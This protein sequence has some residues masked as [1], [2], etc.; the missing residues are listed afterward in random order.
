MIL[1]INVTSIY[2]QVNS[3]N[4]LSKFDKAWL[5]K[6]VSS[7][8][9]SKGDPAL[10]SKIIEQL[11]DGTFIEKYDSF[12]NKQEEITIIGINNIYEIQIDSLK[13]VLKNLKLGDYKKVAKLT[14]EIFNLNVEK[15]KDINSEKVN[16]TKL[17]DLVGFYKRTDVEQK[18]KWF[19]NG[20]TQAKV[21]YDSY[22][23]ETSS[24]SLKNSL[25]TYNTD[26]SSASLYNEFF[27]DYLW[28]G[29]ISLGGLL[30]QTNSTDNK[31][32]E[33]ITQENAIQRL[34]GGGGNV[35]INYAMP[36][37]NW[38]SKMSYHNIFIHM[39]PSF[40]SDIP[41]LG[42]NVDEF[43][44]HGGLAM[45]GYL[46]FSSLKNEFNGYIR[47]KGAWALGNN[48]FASNLNFNEGEHSIWT[49]SISVGFTLAQKYKLIFTHNSESKND[50]LD[51]PFT[52]TFAVVPD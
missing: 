12:L 48:A 38:T 39:Q 21:V 31:S 5:T 51:F 26:N 37:M 32:D 35:A 30:G 50:E 17:K 36:V 43:S 27:A 10:Q 41:A 19:V 7:S 14:E 15:D 22:S 47:A 23:K 33:T 11:N 4:K 24:K 18:P 13:D 40:N 2:S 34:L 8:K 6:E 16:F 45:E 29:R 3:K 1:I 25:F 46:Y 42:S 20:P 28:I 49:S 9:L 52:F 44:F